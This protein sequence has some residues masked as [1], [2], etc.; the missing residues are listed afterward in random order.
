MVQDLVKAGK[1][2]RLHGIKGSLIL[3]PDSGPGPD[4]QKVKTVFLEIN[5]VH[6]PFFVSEIKTSGKNLILTFD[7]VKNPEEAKKLVGKEVWLEKKNL[8]KE[9]K[10]VDYTGYRLIDAEKGD[11]GI[12]L[13][14]MEMPGQRMF[15][16][17]VNDKEVLL[18]FN[19]K[20]IEKAD[21][22][23]KTVFYRAPEGL[24]DIYLD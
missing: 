7:S 20:L 11:L 22:K 18:P 14:I 3:N 1:L 16:L 24:I 2:T 17:R 21:V 5:G 9:K 19:Q 10:Q 13:E 4:A 8:L 23:L 15:S 12:I 6:T